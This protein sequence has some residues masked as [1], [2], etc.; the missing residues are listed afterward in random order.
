LAA[1]INKDE[2]GELMVGRIS[3]SAEGTEPSR[4]AEWIRPQVTFLK[5]NAAKVGAPNRP[6]AAIEGS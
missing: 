1:A 4:Q 5:A 6:E 3:H 2:A